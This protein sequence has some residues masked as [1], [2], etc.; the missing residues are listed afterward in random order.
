MPVSNIA[1]LLSC[2]LLVRLKNGKAT[3]KAFL[4]NTPVEQ[5]ENLLECF[6]MNKNTI[7]KIV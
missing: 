5:K 1:T 3:S 6:T 2:I 7:L 4:K